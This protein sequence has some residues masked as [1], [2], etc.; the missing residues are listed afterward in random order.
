M[1]RSLET[2]NADDI[3]KGIDL[4]KEKIESLKSDPDILKV[5]AHNLIAKQDANQEAKQYRERLEKIDSEY[6]AKEEAR[7][8]ALEEEQLKKKGEFESLYAKSKEELSLKDQKIREMLIQKEIGI[9]AVQMGLKKAQYLK[10][11]DTSNLEVD[12]DSLS[13]KD[14]ES[15]LKKFKEENPD[16]FGDTKKLEVSNAKAKIGSEIPDDDELAKL[17]KRAK[18]TMHPRDIAA[19]QNAKKAKQ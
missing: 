14:A 1:T 6:K 17:E 12:M 18:E 16:F 15:V 19:W 4:P 10:V 5:L 8:K 9:L 3:L 11:L 7:L 13:V 2:L